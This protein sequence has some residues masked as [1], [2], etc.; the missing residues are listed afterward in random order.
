MLEARV[1]ASSFNSDNAGCK[2]SKPDGEVVLRSVDLARDESEPVE[3]RRKGC[4]RFIV[5][6]VCGGGGCCCRDELGRVDA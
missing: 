5:V 2:K 3:G 4:E 1:E 6:D